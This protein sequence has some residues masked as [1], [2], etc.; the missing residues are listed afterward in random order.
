[1][2]LLSNSQTIYARLIR[3]ATKDPYTHASV[4]LR[5]YLTLYGFARRHPHLP[6][7][8]LMRT[9]EPEGARAYAFAA[10]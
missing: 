7:H 1:M 10:Y 6:L 5:E 2:K 9:A 4:S 3:R 8:G